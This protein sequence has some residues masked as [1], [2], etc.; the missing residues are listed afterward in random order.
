[1]RGGINVIVSKGLIDHGKGGAYTFWKNGSADDLGLARNSQD[2]SYVMLSM[3]YYYYLTGDSSILVPIK[4]LIGRCTW[5]LGSLEIKN[6]R[7]LLE[8]AV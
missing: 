2:L 1:M 7:L 8:T 3:T 4:N 5:R 6:S